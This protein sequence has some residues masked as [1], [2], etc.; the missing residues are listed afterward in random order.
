MEMI[1]SLAERLWLARASGVQIPPITELFPQIKIEEAYEISAINLKRRLSGGASLIG[2]KV[3]LT[4]Q[5][6]QK[7]LGVAEPDYG[8]LSSDMSIPNQG[9][10]PAAK[11]IQGKVEGEIA[12]RLAE[13]LGEN[14]SAEDV[15]KATASIEVCIE[16][17]DSRIRDWKIRVEDTIADNASSAFFV[18]S[19]NR[20]SPRGFAMETAKMKL[21]INDELRSEGVGRACMESPL[22]AVAWLARRMHSLRTPLKAGDLILSGAFG[23]VVPVKAGD[24]TRVEIEGLGEVAFKVE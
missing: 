14:A 10:L 3:G 12:F 1:P 23:P 4:S 19:G 6:V 17:I 13:P 18:L 20:A 9:T 7:Q 8:H 11:L 15:L 2:R 22:N 16:V 21:W 24:L 5:A